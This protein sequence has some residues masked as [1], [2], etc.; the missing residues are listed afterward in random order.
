MAE[1]FVVLEGKK[2]AS[3]LSLINDE[4]RDIDQTPVSKMELTAF[5]IMGAAMDPAQ[6]GAVGFFIPLI[7][8]TLTAG[9]GYTR[10]DHSIPCDITGSYTCDV[11]FAGTW[12][13]TTSLFFYGVVVSTIIQAFIFICFGSVADHNA[14]R[15]TLWIIFSVLGSVCCLLFPALVSY[16]MFTFGW[17]LTIIIG[18]CLGACWMLVYAY[19]PLLARN[20]PDFLA[21]AES[22][23]ATRELLLADLDSITNT[24]SSNGFIW[25]YSSTLG[26]LLLVIVFALFYTPAGSLP[27]TYALQLGVALFGIVWLAGVLFV[28][29]HLRT[30]PG[31]P[32]PANSNVMTYS[33][34]KVFTAFSKASKLRHLFFFLIGWFFYGDSFYTLSSVAILWAQS[35]LGFTTKDTLV[36][37]VIVPVCGILGTYLWKRIQDY[38]Q[39]SSKRVL[40]LQNTIY[41]IIPL[42]GCL[43]LIPG[44][45][46]GYQTKIEIYIASAVHGFLLGATQ[47][48]CRSLFAQLLPPG[49]EAEFYSLYEITDK[50]SAWVGPLVVAAID[51]S[52]VNKLYS[53][54]FLGLQF[55]VSL[56]VFSFVNVEKGIDD[57]RGVWEGGEGEGRVVISWL[58]LC[59]VWHWDTR[60]RRIESKMKKKN[61]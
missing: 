34:K 14:Y 41:S 17:I 53:M 39:I 12:V 29:K 55:L 13:D 16:S 6:F 15:K 37:A 19:L 51:N 54:V 22:P 32:F 21:K 3:A 2:N 58:V 25:M 47:S 49:S 7:V 5:Y 26:F 44:S 10:A 11:Q 60:N 33:T 27:P 38:T 57:G 50:G 8:Q 43:G 18:V 1:D 35:H 30:R 31:P 36:L 42:W 20:H 24:I 9:Y 56:W 40:L 28:N 4:F 48:T 23:D 59:S 46:L 45:P 52:G 61:E